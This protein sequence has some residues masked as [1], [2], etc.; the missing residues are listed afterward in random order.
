MQHWN[1]CKQEIADGQEKLAADVSRGPHGRRCASRRHAGLH[2]RQSGPTGRLSPATLPADRRRRRAP[3]VHARQRS[4]RTGRSHRRSATTRSRLASW[5]I[6]CGSITSAAAS[7]NTPSNFGSLGE[8]PTHPELLDYLAVR[9]VESGWSMKALHRE[10]MLSAAYQIEFA[11]RRRERGTRPGQSP[12]VAHAAAATRR[13][14][15]ARRVAG[16]LGPAR[17]ATRRHGRPSRSTTWPTSAA[18][19][20]ARSAVMI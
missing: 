19:S 13:R 11:K 14:S 20:T 8:R 10:I 18:R 4:P 5:S 15:V 16:R 17:S 9:F 2:P 6:A 1:E 3:A 12:L 7:S